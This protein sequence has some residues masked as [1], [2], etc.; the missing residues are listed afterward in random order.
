MQRASIL[1]FCACIA[2]PARQPAEPAAR[3]AVRVI[4][5]DRVPPASLAAAEHLAGEIFHDAG[6]GIEWVDCNAAARP[7]TAEA[8]ATDFWLQLLARRPNAVPGLLDRD[9]TGYALLPPGC[10]ACGYAAVSYPAVVSLSHAMDRSVALLLGPAMAHE[11][12]HLLLG[13]DSHAPAGIMSPRLGPEQ[14]AQAG[15]GLLRFLPGEARRL[16]YE[17]IARMAR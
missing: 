13:H 12:G 6:V 10:A 3:I 16:R 14:I 11:I 15:R 17:V 7:C 9:A 1:L 2:A 5:S 4:G 8:K